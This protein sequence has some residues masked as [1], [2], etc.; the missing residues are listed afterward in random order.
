M[1][2][3]VPVS[4][5]SAETAAAWHEIVAASLA[6]DLPDEPRPTVKQIEAQLTASG[7][8][9]RRLHWLATEPD[10]AVSGVAGLRLFTSPGQDHLAEVE[11]HVNP[12]RRRCGI[13]SQL[14]HAAV[15]AAKLDRRRS[16]RR[17]G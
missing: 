17:A 3:I 4:Q 11:L 8:D 12:S 16:R 14:L 15:S 10:G 5:V 13:A 6:Y 9:S 7:L 2:R 1:T